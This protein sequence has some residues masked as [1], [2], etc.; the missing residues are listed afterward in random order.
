MMLS[1][2]VFILLVTSAFSLVGAT[3]E[4]MTEVSEVQHRASLRLRFLE[5][6]RAAFE[7]A[8][9]ESGLEFDFIDRGGQR[10]D[11]YLSLVSNPAAFDFGIGR[12]QLVERVIL[13]AEI[14]PDGFIRAR[15]YYLDDEAYGRARN[16]DFSEFE[17]AHVDLIPRMRQLT[18]RF[19][20]ARG[21]EW[22]P[23]PEGGARNF[24]VELTI[25]VD[26]SSPPIRTVFQYTGGAR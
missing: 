24:L 16:S 8:N 21:Q 15:A 19:Y 22:K 1:V 11:T 17:G 25:Q 13:A 26:S 6:T 18:W 5:A 7:S 4:L 12:H 9:S 10:Y 2:A 14:Q 3:T 20:E 23:L